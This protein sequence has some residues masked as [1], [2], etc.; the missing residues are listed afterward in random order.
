MCCVTQEAC[1]GGELFD[2][3]LEKG[4]FTELDAAQIVKVVLQVIQHCHL[5]GIVHRGDDCKSLR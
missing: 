5:K 2:L 4:H 1:L 3:I